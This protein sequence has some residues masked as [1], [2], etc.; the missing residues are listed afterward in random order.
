MGTPSRLQRRNRDAQRP[1]NKSAGADLGICNFAAVSYS[2]EEAD[3]Y[4]SNR[5]KR[6][7][8]YFP[9]EI[10]KCDDLIFTNPLIGGATCLLR[11]Q[12]HS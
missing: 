5:L 1:G 6:D 2:T 12:L 3:L 4:P 7:E 8:Y 11:Q 10:T 9:K